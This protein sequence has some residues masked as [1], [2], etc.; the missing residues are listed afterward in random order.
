MRELIDE[1]GETILVYAIGMSIVMLFKTI[2]S[3]VIY[4]QCENLQTNMRKR[5]ISK[6]FKRA[7]GGV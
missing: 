2:L 6:S 4:T 3:M 7:Q 1:Y 5:Y